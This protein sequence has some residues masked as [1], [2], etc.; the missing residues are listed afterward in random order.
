MRART[1]LDTARVLCKREHES[2]RKSLA[3]PL[4]EERPYSKVLLGKKPGACA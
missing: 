4:L 3:H 1:A 2:L